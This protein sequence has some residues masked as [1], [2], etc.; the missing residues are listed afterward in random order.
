M[1]TYQLILGS[2]LGLF[3][4]LVASVAS[5]Q[6]LELISRQADAD[7]GAQGDNQSGSPSISADA[8]LVVF[9]SVAGNLIPGI[10]GNQLYLFDRQTGGLELISRQGAA[11][12]GAPANDSSFSP[13]ISADG[14]FVAFRSEATNL[15]P[16]GGPDVN[17]PGVAGQDIFVLDRQTGALELISRQDAADGGA[18]TNGR[19]FDARISANGRF[20]AFS[21]EAT[22]LIPGGGP[23]VNGSL[24]DVFVF[25]RQTGGLELVSRQSDADGAAQSSERSRNPSISAD[26]RFVVFNSRA[27]NLIPGGGPDANGFVADVFVFDRQTGGLELVSRQGDADGGAQGNFDSFAYSISAD[28]RLVA[29]NSRATNLIPGGGPDTNGIDR[30]VF[31]F[32]RQTGG[33]ELV[34]RQDAADGGA[35]GNDDSG[36]IGSLSAFSTDGRFVTF[37]SNATNLIPGGEPDANGGGFL[38]GEDVFVF[39]RQT[40]GLEL[41]SCQ[42]AADGGF[43]ANNSSDSPVISADG[44][45]VAFASRA[46]NLIPGGVPDVNGDRIDVFISFD[47]AESCAVAPPPPPPKQLTLVVD[48]NKG[49]IEVGDPCPDPRNKRK[50][51]EIQAAV[52]CAEPGDIVRL[53]QGAYD[54]SVVV[55]KGLWLQ[56]SG[57]LQTII[58]GMI[59]VDVAS[60]KLVRIS[61]MTLATGEV[62]PVSEGCLIDNVNGRVKIENVLFSI[63]AGKIRVAIEGL[64]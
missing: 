24:P 5:A 60:D 54:E 55:D 9:Q 19:S 32:D 20:V 28:G 53:R 62:P 10:G 47:R 52:N 17:G 42:D 27:T 34:S 61:A 39:D 13:S 23:D 25:D 6:S 11:D 45:F 3:A 15:I 1:R 38:S 41:V 48:Q 58:A 30:D 49:K 22:N 12:G 21:S 50:F 14:R 8:R 31:V 36:G 43:Q 26:G 59:E 37:F 40:S 35:Q 56:G 57:I 7:G 4:L 2:A 44:R 18:Q 46:T 64:S 63:G 51:R 16:G 29:F 33:I